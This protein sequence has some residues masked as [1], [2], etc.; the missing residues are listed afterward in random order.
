MNNSILRGY[1]ITVMI[2]Y[3]EMHQ[4]LLNQST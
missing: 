1:V 3:F 2:T 4:I